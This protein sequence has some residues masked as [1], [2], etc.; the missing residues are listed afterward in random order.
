[1]KHHITILVVALMIAGGAAG[2]ELQVFH[3]GPDVEYLFADAPDTDT[4]I[5]DEKARVRAM[6]S[7]SISLEWVP[8]FDSVHAFEWGAWGVEAHMGKGNDFVIG[9]DTDDVIFGRAGRDGIQGRGGN[10]L[11]IGGSDA[12]VLTG[13]IGNDVLIGGEGRDHLVGGPGDDL[14]IGGPGKDR[15]RI[16]TG[17]DTI[18]LRSHKD[19]DYMQISYFS[20]KSGSRRI[21][22]DSFDISKLRAQGDALEHVGTFE[23]LHPDDL[24]LPSITI[25]GRDFTLD[26]SGFERRAYRVTGHSSDHDQYTLNVIVRKR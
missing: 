8:R 26:A 2:A 7:G 23:R 5:E 17:L 25:G 11:L 24:T 18:V 22:H 3:G 21:R 6:G 10:D 12:D 20:T 13:G 9:T 1:M 14:I 4:A 19:P 15:I 16:E